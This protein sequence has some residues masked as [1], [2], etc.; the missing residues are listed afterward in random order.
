MNIAQMCE[1]EYQSTHDSDKKVYPFRFMRYPIKLAVPYHTF[2][3]ENLIYIY[4]FINS[5]KALL[6]SILKII[7]NNPWLLASLDHPR[8]FISLSL[9]E[10]KSAFRIWTS[11]SSR[12]NFAAHDVENTTALMP[13]EKRISVITVIRC[14]HNRKARTC[15]RY[16]SCMWTTKHL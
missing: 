1:D 12:Y 2:G 16:T 3:V 13:G 10:K 11:W 15:K 9:W 7:P 6:R 8:L 4:R 5:D 14:P